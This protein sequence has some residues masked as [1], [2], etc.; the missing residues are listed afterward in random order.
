[1]C[2]SLL[3]ICNRGTEVM[4][5]R[6]TGKVK[7]TISTDRKFEDPRGRSFPMA[8]SYRKDRVHWIGIHKLLPNVAVDDFKNRLELLVTK[9]LGF[10]VV[11]N[12]IQLDFI[13]SNNV[14][15]NYVE[16][17]GLPA[18]RPIVL[19]RGEY[20]TRDHVVQIAE[21]PGVQLLVQQAPE[22][23]TGQNL[24]VLVA[25]SMVL[26]DKESQTNSNNRV[27]R[28]VIHEV[29]DGVAPQE[30]EKKLA[31]ISERFNKLAVFQKNVLRRTVFATSVDNLDSAMHQLDFQIA[32]HAFIYHAEYENRDTMI[33]L[34]NSAEY[35]QALAEM[36]KICN[37]TM[38][39][40]D[41]V[42]TKLNEN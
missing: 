17:A 34:V 27:H 38:F 37:V 3:H 28:F 31:A 30:C 9:S 12:L 16:A 5:S 8:Y 4:V 18:P 20:A 1:M 11:Q 6:S 32:K 7:L 40:A 22:L 10:P 33:E 23:K 26:M 25:D 2:D 15:D 29:P 39:C 41:I 21:D 42:S 13:I 24:S 35:K 19:S 36:K 14:L